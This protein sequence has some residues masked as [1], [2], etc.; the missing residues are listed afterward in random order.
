MTLLEV[1]MTLLEVRMR[2]QPIS[3]PF[4]LNPLRYE[5]GDKRCSDL[6]VRGKV[7]KAHVPQM[8]LALRH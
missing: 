7:P 6:C 8:G 1:R 2:L 4:R 5:Q 3:I